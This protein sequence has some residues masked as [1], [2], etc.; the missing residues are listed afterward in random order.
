MDL[1]IWLKIIRKNM[2]RINST[3]IG[4]YVISLI[5]I[6]ALISCNERNEKLVEIDFTQKYLT[7][8]ND[9]ASDSD[10]FSIKN[11]GIGDA[12]KREYVSRGLEWR[13]VTIFATIEV[14]NTTSDNLKLWL[15]GS[16]VEGY[17]RNDTI[18]LF[19]WD[20]LGIVLKPFEKHEFVVTTLG[21]FDGNVMYDFEPYFGYKED[22]TEDMIKLWTEMKI[23]YIPNFSNLK[24]PV[25]SVLYYREPTLI[26]PSRE[27]KATVYNDKDNPFEYWWRRKIKKEELPFVARY[28]ELQTRYN[29]P[30]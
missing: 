13:G 23:M 10:I 3:H 22:Y 26:K 24:N 17:Y 11:I 1:K 25:D 30:D 15:N 27:V 29:L 2:E 9:Y 8:I 7:S 28:K 19:D 6:M 5:A 4:V 12:D 16:S 14:H 20:Y 18:H 21:P